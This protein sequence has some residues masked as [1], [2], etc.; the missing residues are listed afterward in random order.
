MISYPI[1][2]PISCLIYLTFLCVQDCVCL[3]APYPFRNEPLDEFN[4]TR[5]FDITGAGEVWYE[6]AHCV[7]LVQ[8][9]ILKGT[10]SFHSYSSAPLSQSAWPQTAVCSRRAFPCCTSCL[11]QCCLL[12][13]SVLS[14]TYLGV[15]LWFRATW[16]GTPAI[17]SHTC[18][19]A[20]SQLRRRQ[21]QDRTVGP[22]AGSSRSTYG[23]GATEDRFH[24]MWLWQIL[25]PWGSN[26]L[27]N[28]G[29]GGLPP[30][31][32]GASRRPVTASD[33]RKTLISGAVISGTWKTV[34]SPWPIR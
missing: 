22:V 17:P 12:S 8:W 28:P 29:H 6:S 14:R 9:N 3:V 15:S 20:L 34:I 33:I 19:E 2:Y 4:V 27:R 30:F 11:V 7:P 31:S 13:T 18:T 24:W 23:C 25:W 1:S 32:V 16:M 5:D 21:I 10:R 26:E